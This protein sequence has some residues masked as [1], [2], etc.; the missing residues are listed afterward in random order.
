MRN[1]EWHCIVEG[2]DVQSH[3]FLL[4]T[5]PASPLWMDSLSANHVPSYDRSNAQERRSS[6][7]LVPV[8]SRCQARKI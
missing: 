2:S 6:L 3:S 8:V 4:G 5:S 7:S 1:R